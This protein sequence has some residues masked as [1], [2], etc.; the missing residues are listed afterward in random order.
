MGNIYIAHDEEV[1]AIC[2]GK[3]DEGIK[4]DIGVGLTIF[5]QRHGLSFNEKRRAEYKKWLGITMSVDEE[6]SLID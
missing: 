2:S 5:D 3:N 6:R 1:K 4:Y